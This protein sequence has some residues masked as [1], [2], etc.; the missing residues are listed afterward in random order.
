MGVPK[1]AAEGGYGCTC[2]AGGKLRKL[3]CGER[4]CDSCTR[5]IC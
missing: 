4:R 2:V 3:V 1:G 5:N